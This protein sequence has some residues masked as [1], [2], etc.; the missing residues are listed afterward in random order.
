[1]LAGVSAEYY[2]QIE[3]GRVAGVSDEVLLAIARALRLDDVETD[4]FLALA[5]AASSR[6][7]RRPARPRAVVSPALQSILDSMVTVP[8]VVLAPNLDVV[9]GNALGLALY[10]PTGGPVGKWNVARFLF[11][12]PK[13]DHAFPTWNTAADD[14]VALLRGAA[15]ADPNAKSLTALVGELSTASAEFRTK[16]A[17]HR[18][19]AH[20][21]GRKQFRHDEVG[22]LELA[23]EAL[24]I[25]GS[26]GLTLYAFPPEPASPAA[27]A[28]RLLSSLVADRPATVLEHH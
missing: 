11:L 12:D 26:G 6:P 24:D 9:A 28:L 3:R 7:N 18:I 17:A 14:A 25:A 27:D 5:R 8:A 15:A 10:A 22:G 13:A 23:F 20:R 16:W 1:M 21:R 4:H 19:V 2:I